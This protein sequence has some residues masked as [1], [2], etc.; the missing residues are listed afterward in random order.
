MLTERSTLTAPPCVAHIRRDGTGEVIIAG[1]THLLACEDLDAVRIEAM[2][3]VAET[4]ADLA[5]PVPVFCTEPDGVFK[6]VI[7]PD[8]SV[9]TQQSP[10]LPQDPTRFSSSDRSGP[11]LFDVMGGNP[12]PRS[13]GARTSPKSSP[14]DTYEEDADDPESMLGWD[15]DAPAPPQRDCVIILSADGQGGVQ[16]DDH[17]TAV[18]AP[19]LMTA[20]RRAI[21]VVCEEARRKG[22]YLFVVCQDPEGAFRLLVSPDGN[23]TEAAPPPG[24]LES[25]LQELR[26]TFDPMVINSLPRKDLPKLGA[27]APLSPPTPVTRPSASDPFTSFPAG[28]PPQPMGPPQP[29][30]TPKPTTILEPGFFD[31]PPTPAPPTPRTAAIL[32]PGFF[33]HPPTPETTQILSRSE[34]LFERIVGGSKPGSP[35]RKPSPAPAPIPPIPPPPPP[36]PAPAPRPEPEPAPLPEPTPAPVAEPEPILPPALAPAEVAALVEANIPPVDDDFFDPFDNI[37]ELVIAVEPMIE[38]KAE[39][40]SEPLPRITPTGTPPVVH[41]ETY[42]FPNGPPGPGPV[43]P[44]IQPPPEPKLPLAVPAAQAQ[45]FTSYGLPKHPPTPAMR[46]LAPPPPIDRGGAEPSRSPFPQEITASGMLRPEPVKRSGFRRKPS[47][48]EMAERAY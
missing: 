6:L 32:E 25:S 46:P 39:P 15:W 18:M 24:G 26:L 42:V 11:A 47:A 23:V 36:A 27:Q 38:P 10:P 3:L 2:I 30:A 44:E 13:P 33:D 9:D 43:I 5:Q 34:A 40:V 7:N 29:K 8:G 21:G 35:G 28:P 16:I 31:Q 12:P 20:R 1:V 41:T 48:G 22:D 45:V 4:A 19:D 17:V 37:N 14:F